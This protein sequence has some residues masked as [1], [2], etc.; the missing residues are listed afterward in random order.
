MSTQGYAFQ[1]DSRHQV[2][3]SPTWTEV[4]AY[5]LSRLQPADRRPNHSTLLSALRNSHEKGLPDISTAPAVAKMY[6]LQ[7]RANSTSHA[8]E[9]GT[10]GG[11][12]SLYLA[13]VNPGMRVMT[14]EVNPHHHAVSL[15]NIRNGGPEIASRIDVRLG[16]ALD[17]LP[18]LEQEIIGEGKSEKFGF[19]YIDADKANN[20]TYVD[21][22]IPLCKKG[23]VIYVDNV[24]RGGKLVDPDAIDESTLGA[25]EVVERVGRDP[26]LDAVVMQFVG[27][28][29]YDGMIMAVVL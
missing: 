14:I 16:A 19:V 25:R 9:I 10:L 1:G 5:T 13:S 18:L 22:V 12:T 4:D 15:E 11:Y 27:E 29:G 8:L 28:K 7:C 3:K 21:K 20:W 2:K 23:A 17:V 24:V 6:A 26:R